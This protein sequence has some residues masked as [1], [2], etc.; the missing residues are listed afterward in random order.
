MVPANYK[1][2]VFKFA[3]YYDNSNIKTSLNPIPKHNPG[4]KSA[5]LLQKCS[6]TIP[7][8]CGNK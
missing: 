6:S 7:S 5:F 1:I 4:P 3:I 8:F 2:K